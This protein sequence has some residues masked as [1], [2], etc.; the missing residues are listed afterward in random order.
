MFDPDILQKYPI[1]REGLK[2]IVQSGIC[3]EQIQRL[4]ERISFGDADASDESIVADV[5]KFR[6]DYG[7]VATLRDLG[8]SF[9]SKENGQ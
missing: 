1:A 6:K 3:D 4:Q 8:E 2:L 5:R 7:M 9:I